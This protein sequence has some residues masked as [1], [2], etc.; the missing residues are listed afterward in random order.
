MFAI[1]GSCFNDTAATLT[2]PNGTNCFKLTVQTNLTTL[3]CTTSAGACSL[4]SSSGSYGDGTTIYFIVERTCPAVGQ[5]AAA[6]TV[7]FH[8]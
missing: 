8:L 7:N 6:Y 4:T 3:S 1:G 5:A 2:V